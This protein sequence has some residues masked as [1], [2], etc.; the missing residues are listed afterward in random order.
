MTSPVRDLAALGWDDAWAASAAVHPEEC[1]PGRIARVDRGLCTVLSESGVVRASWGSDLLDEVATDATVT[2]CTGDWA[3]LR[4]W[5]DGP[6]TVE[7]VLPRRTAIVRADAAG[8]S[9]GQVLAANIDLVAVV[10][11]LHPEP[12]LSRLE[13]LLA[14][15]WESGAQPLVVLTKAD[16]VADA[17]SL[18]EDVVA[19]APGVAVIVCS[20][21][22]GA[23]IEAVRATI[24]ES[25]TMAMLGVSGHGKSSLTNALV[26]AEV[27]AVRSIRDDGKGRH[28]SVRREL[29]PLPTGG[30]VI[31]TPGL[32]GV[33]LQ[34]AAT[35]MA[36]TFPDVVELAALCRFS[37]CS[38]DGEPACAVQAAVA[39][40]TLA[41]RRLDSWRR[42]QREV[43]WMAARSDA[44][45]RS[46]QL[47]KWKQLTKQH[48]TPRRGRV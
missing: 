47:K 30:T 7:A 15:A 11:A 45:L 27:L 38:H 37:D 3:L 20:T 43:A 21:V 1:V 29:L 26:G 23:G 24:G 25:S 44:R 8:T 6:T 39:A 32:R 40:G 14:L 13:R 31:D 16:L 10:V 18:A 9:F 41:V 12:N 19:A 35:G 2:P 48:R 5:P 22:T 4:D 42:L 46:E 28:T 33:G 34:E 36:A 17:D